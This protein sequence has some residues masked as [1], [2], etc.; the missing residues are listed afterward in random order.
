MILG[1]LT[2]R[3]NPADALNSWL[4]PGL[5][6]VIFI[7]VVFNLAALK[8]STRVVVE[9]RTVIG[10]L[11]PHW[12]P[13]SCS[14]WS[15]ITNPDVVE[16]LG[17]RRSKA[18]NRLSRTVMTVMRFALVGFSGIFI[19][20]LFQLFRS[21]PSLVGIPVVLVI[22]LVWFVVSDILRSRRRVVVRSAMMRGTQFLMVLGVGGLLL[23][24]PT[25]AFYNELG[26]T[27]LAL[28]VSWT[29]AAF[30]AVP[31]VAVIP[32]S[33]VF[34]LSLWV[35]APRLDKWSRDLFSLIMTANVMCAV[36]AGIIVAIQPA[37]EIRSGK[38]TSESPAVKATCTLS[39]GAWAP[40]WAIGRTGNPVLANRIIGA[41]QNIG[42][43]QVPADPG[44]FRVVHMSDSC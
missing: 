29:E 23:R 5:F 28:T 39:D 9:P 41:D 30:H 11:P 36:L 27:D 2:P 38:V 17:S 8:V 33:A 6:V 24:L 18:L 22:V 19:Y 10:V 12:S 15:D 21:T 25:L 3:F 43:L 20:L 34:C 4:I 40:T 26:A 44:T 13:Y 7:F 31:L 1:V 35:L 16:I 14:I 32:G 37:A 42:P